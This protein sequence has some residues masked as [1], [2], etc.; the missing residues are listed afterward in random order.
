MSSTQAVDVLVNNAGAVEGIQLAEVEFGG[1]LEG[2]EVS[3]WWVA[4]RVQGLASDEARVQ[5]MLSI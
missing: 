5:H 3:G 2:G 1:G 4:A